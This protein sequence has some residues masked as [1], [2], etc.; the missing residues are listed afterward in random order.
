[1]KLL[2]KGIIIYKK[3]IIITLDPQ[4][5]VAR[6]QMKDCDGIFLDK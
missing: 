1:M 3:R 4:V 2:M 5:I 6:V